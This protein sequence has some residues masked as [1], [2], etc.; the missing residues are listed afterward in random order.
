[1]VQLIWRQHRNELFFYGGLLLLWCVFCLILGNQMHAAMLTLQQHGCTAASTD[2]ICTNLQIDYI[3]QFHH[4]LSIMP[5][6]LQLVP[7]FVGMLLGAPLI[8]REFEQRTH[9]FLWA[10]S[11]T[12]RR[13]AIGKVGVIV[14]FCVLAAA[15]YS[16]LFV[17]CVS[18]GYQVNGN[19]LSQGNPYTQYDLTGIVPLG[20]IAFALAVGIA[21]G[22][23]FRRTIV[24]MP[25]VLLSY[26][27]VRTIVAYFRY[28]WVTP[29]TYTY[30]DN[31]S[32]PS[33]VANGHP[34]G[35]GYMDAHGAIV[36]NDTVSNACSTSDNF[37]NCLQ[38]HGWMNYE[39]VI[40]PSDF[41]MIQGVETAVF[42]LLAIGLLMFA[43]WHITRQSV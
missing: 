34:V 10:Q 25:I 31:G 29:A 27:I 7:V 11:I 17:W 22:V 40:P 16:A 37:A 18:Q 20:Y 39:K 35:G 24:A 8:A 43:I 4:F 13:W 26:P 9:L 42:G 28:S 36:T 15:L 38:T 21:T 2:D 14:I 41:W 23:I 5:L 3:D 1:M 30:L 12:R 19:I 32:L 33:W 6:I